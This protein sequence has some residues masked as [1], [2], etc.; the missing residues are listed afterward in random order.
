MIFLATIALYSR[1][2]FLLPSA[3]RSIVVLAF[4]LNSDSCPSIVSFRSTP[5]I[6]EILFFED[7]KNML[8]FRTTIYI[9]DYTPS[10]DPFTTLISTPGGRR[11]VST[12][13]MVLFTRIA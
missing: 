13:A 1:S 12:L 5:R 11:L 4:R 6:I 8:E 10:T 2:I 9:P 3:V 7:F